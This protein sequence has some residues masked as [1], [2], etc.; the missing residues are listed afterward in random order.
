MTRERKGID[1]RWLWAGLAIVL[2]AVFYLVRSL[3][4][5]RL[6]V[7]VATVTRENLASTVST[8]GRV[9]P[10]YNH[11]LHS[12]ISTTV[13]AVYVQPGDKVPAGK[14]LM[15]L[16]DTEARARLAAAESGVKTAQAGLE[17][18]MNNGSREQQ[19]T[20]KADRTRSKLERDQAA[21]NLEALKKL[22]ATGAASPSEVAAAQQRLDAANAKLETADASAQQRFGSADVAQAR[23]ALADAEANLAAAREVEAQTRVRAPI[24]GTVYSMNAGPTEYVDQGKLLLEVADLTQERIRAYFDEPEIGLLAVGQPIAIKWDALPGRVWH[25]H[26]ERVP[27]TVVTQTTRTVGEVLVK[28]NDSDSGLLPDTN[29]TVT[30]TTSDEP[31]ALSIPRQCLYSEN[32]KAYVFKLVDGELKR[33]WV[34]LGPYNLTLASI[35]SGLKVGDVVATGT[36]SGQP[37]Q[38]GVPIKVVQ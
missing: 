22:H 20:S 21:Q 29:V 11:E 13:K 2:V 38:E 32:G 19:L 6:P 17:A 23:A 27:V 36:S 24:S 30:V 8:N 18:V 37:L 34:Q 3:S 4:V 5:D 16:D 31:D 14:L 33:T 10:E 12:P 7:R 26:I 25:G 15:V 28:I 9:E 35:R 1:R